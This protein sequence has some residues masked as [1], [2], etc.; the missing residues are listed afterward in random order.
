MLIVVYALIGLVCL[1]NFCL[2]KALVRSQK[3]QTSP[4]HP[5]LA[6]SMLLLPILG[7]GFIMA[8]MIS[9]EEYRYLPGMVLLVVS[10]VPLM[11][12]ALRPQ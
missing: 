9:L 2:Y 4:I 3:N 6:W 7:V 12:R 10:L 1:L 11:T 5:A 8:I